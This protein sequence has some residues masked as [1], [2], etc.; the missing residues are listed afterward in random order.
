MVFVALREDRTEEHKFRA[1]IARFD[2]SPPSLLG[3]FALVELPLEDDTGFGYA[4][5]SEAPLELPVVFA[6]HRF[7]CTIRSHNVNVFLF[8]GG[9]KTE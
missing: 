9:P 1:K 8:G 3:E 5:V 2:S 6:E 4:E 7:C